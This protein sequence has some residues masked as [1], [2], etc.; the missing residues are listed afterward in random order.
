LKKVSREKDVGK[1]E[2]ERRKRK[3]TA[4]FLNRLE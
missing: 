1:E 4:I 3:K 2:K